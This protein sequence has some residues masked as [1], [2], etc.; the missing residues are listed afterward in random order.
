M[1]VSDATSIL[2]GLVMGSVIYNREGDG[3]GVKFM[4]LKDG[5]EKD[6]HEFVA[7]CLDTSPI[8]NSDHK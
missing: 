4:T 5:F 1:L 8:E 7:F 2:E 6:I 3:F